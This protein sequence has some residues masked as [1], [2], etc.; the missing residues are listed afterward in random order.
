MQLADGDFSRC[1]DAPFAI[2]QALFASLRR[3][4]VIMQPAGLLLKTMQR[5]GFLWLNGAALL[6]LAIIGCSD[7]SGSLPATTDDSTSQTAFPTSL[8]VA[9]P[10]DWSSDS[11]TRTRAQGSL[12]RSIPAIETGSQYG[13]AIAAI[14]DILTGTSTSSCTFDPQLFFQVVTNA[15]CYGPNVKYEDHPD[16]PTP[17]NG[18]LPPGDTGI[19]LEEDPT[20]GD[21]CA[22]AELN[23]RMEGIQARS[24]GALLGL[25]S[26]VCTINASGG[27]L[28]LPDAT[29]TIVDLTVAMPAPNGVTF[30]SA[31]LAYATTTGGET[32]YT[33]GLDFDYDTHHIVVEMA[34]IPDATSTNVYRGQLTYRIST[35]TDGGSNCPEVSGSTPVTRNGSLVYNRTADSIMT[36]EMREAQFCGSETNGLDSDKIVDATNEFDP[37]LAPNGWGD[38]FSLFRNEFDPTTLLGNYAYFWQA[39]HGDGNT[40]VFN[41][42][43]Y[44]DGDDATEDLAATAFFGYG[45]DAENADP[46]IHGF[47]FNWAGPGNNHNLQEYA[48]KQQ[49]SYNA[50]TGKFDSVSANIHYA[51]T[52]TGNYDG[53]GSFTYDSDADGF[54][55]TIPGNAITHD[56]A[57]STDD[58]TGN[59]TIEQTIVDAGIVVPSQPD[60]S[61]CAP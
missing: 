34:H 25:A 1:A 3:V 23:A 58:G 29:N 31:V 17:N 7:S 50:T 44:D 60:C 39:G 8:A 52:T 49:V 42:R 15:G 43:V 48:Q 20:T 40:R 24:L 28:S 11:G 5:H 26:M 47:I 16:A 59:F 19:W 27:S 2:H 38:D 61:E 36:M 18:D 4:F 35:T 45:I 37:G 53:M 51:P 12:S 14:N 54:V 55:D 13:A 10:L 9:S 41:L 30:N 57:A 22:A 21:A 33:Y 56:L 46:S 6:F 32:K